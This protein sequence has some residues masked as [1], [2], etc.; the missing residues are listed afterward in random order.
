M[1]LATRIGQEVKSVK[2]SKQDK[3]YTFTVNESEIVSGLGVDGNTAIAKDTLKE[4]IKTAGVWIKVVNAVTGALGYAD[5]V[6]MSKKAVQSIEYA[7]ST[8]DATINNYML[9]NYGRMRQGMVFNT[10]SYPK[11]KVLFS[12]PS[13]TASNPMLAVG[14]PTGTLSNDRGILVPTGTSKVYYVQLFLAVARIWVSTDYGKTFTTSFDRN[15]AQV[16][17]GA[18]HINGYLIITTGSTTS[19]GYEMSYTNNDGATWA[20]FNHGYYS[21]M[22]KPMQ[23]GSALFVFLSG[24]S[25]T[26][27]GVITNGTSMSTGGI[28]TSAG[29][30]YANTGCYNGSVYMVCQ[31]TNAYTSANAVATSWTSRTLVAT[32]YRLF[33]IGSKIVY[34]SGTDSYVSTDNAATFTKYA[35]VVPFTTASIKFVTGNSN[36]ALI[37]SDDGTRLA[38]T[39]NG[40]TY[41]EITTGLTNP[42]SMGCTTGNGNYNYIQG[43]NGVLLFDGSASTY[44][45]TATC[46]TQTEGTNEY[47]FY[48]AG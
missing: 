1:T 40:Q 41:V 4:Y 42:T 8:T 6:S 48:I 2:N 23:L 5:I 26:N 45:S 20:I 17:S 19:T 24:A 27:Y 22:M 32:A 34:I 18:G 38:W 37:S 46:D 12:T 16:P 39:T 21:T 15:T 13:N 3:I 25:G 47:K 10:A 7:N 9:T 35:G 44:P 11:F 29:S 28:T 33:A 30:F 14:T 31:G 43:T 36:G